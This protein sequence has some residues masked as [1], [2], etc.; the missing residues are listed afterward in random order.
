[1]VL[2]SFHKKEIF[3]KV[4]AEVYKKYSVS[5]D[6]IYKKRGILKVVDTKM[7]AFYIILKLFTVKKEE[8]YKGIFPAIQFEDKIKLKDIQE[9]FKLKS[10]CNIIY[11]AKAV[12]DTMDVY[13]SKE[14]KISALYQQCRDVIIEYC[15][16]NHIEFTL[17]ERR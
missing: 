4:A 13:P 6:N 11:S 17:N 1:M 9:T 2:Q 7:I 15:T 12:S 16:E 5:L 8:K 14:K 10:H 3:L